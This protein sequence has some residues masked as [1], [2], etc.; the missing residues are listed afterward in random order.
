MPSEIQACTPRPLHPN[1][2]NPNSVLPYG[3]QIEHIRSAMERFL[4]FIGFVN[5]Q[6]RRKKTERLESFLMPANFSS[7]VGE[8]MTMT[9]PKFCPTIVKNNHH[10]GHPDLLPKGVFP[11]DCAQHATEGIEVKASRYIKSWQGHNP[12]NVFLMVFCFDSNRPT[13]IVGGI[14]PRPFAFAATLGALLDKSDWKYAGRSA[15]SRRTP[16]ASVMK[17]GLLKMQ[18]NWIYS[19]PGLA[20]SLVVKE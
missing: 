10:N 2:F 11:G 19:D 20:D 12:E 13:D 8:F 18:E 16:T 4:D 15:T 17:S 3:C 9:I 7:I 1:G 14:A 6:L 5:V